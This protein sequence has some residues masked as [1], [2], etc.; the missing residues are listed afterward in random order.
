MRRAEGRR[1]A[2]RQPPDE[3]ARQFLKHLE[4]ARNASP[5]TLRA[6]RRALEQFRRS[7]GAKSWRAATAED[8][9]RHL[10]S[11]SVSGA[12]RA[13]I[14]ASFA[15]LRSFGN[16]LEE[17]GI[18]QGN[19]A[20][21]VRLPKLEKRLP[22]FLTSSQV[23]ALLAAPLAQP[24]TR[25]A[26]SWQALRDAAIWELFYSTGIRVAELAGLDVRDLDPIAENIRVMGK[27]GKQR[28]VPVGEPALEAI[29]RYRA[30]ASVHSGPLFINKSRRRLSCRAVDAAMKKHLAAAGLPADITP[31]KL[32]HTFAT[33]MLDAGADLRSVQELLGHASLSTTQIYTHVTAERLRRAYDAAHPRA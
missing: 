15:A 18:L 30:A 19:P 27:G 6:Y 16:F 23:E 26:T 22:V 2:A 25:Q 28:V 11:L 12:S 5:H 20:A 10:F 21:A 8:Y 17:R 32:R 3:L 31:H 29:S 4:A 7:L 33:H 24:K 1:L 9:R 14:R 13:T